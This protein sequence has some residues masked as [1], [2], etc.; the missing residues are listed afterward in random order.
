MSPTIDPLLLS[1]LVP[2]G[3]SPDLGSFH[4][5]I[6]S[7]MGFWREAGESDGV[8]GRRGRV[9]GLEEQTVLANHTHFSRTCVQAGNAFFAVPEV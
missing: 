5:A 9:M 1:D 8:G 7:V 6:W 4:S 3:S 2:E